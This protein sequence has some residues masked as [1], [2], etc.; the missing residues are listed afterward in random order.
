MDTI[1]EPLLALDKHLRVVTASRSFYLKFL[2]DQQD[3]RGRRVYELGDGQWNI[4]ELRKLLEEI[5]PRHTVMEGYE[6]EQN[7][8]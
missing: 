5:L 2:S 1:R 6:V 7:F 8:S 3:V 4:S